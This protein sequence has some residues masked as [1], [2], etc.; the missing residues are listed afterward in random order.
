LRAHRQSD[1][2]GE[3]TDDCR[4]DNAIDD[5]AQPHDVGITGVDIL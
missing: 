1:T 2:V 4:S 5:A 3:A